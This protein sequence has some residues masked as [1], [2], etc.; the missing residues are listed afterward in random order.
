MI[1]QICIG[2]HILLTWVVVGY[3]VNICG[4]NSAFLWE[5]LYYSLQEWVWIFGDLCNFCWR[6]LWFYLLLFSWSRVKLV[7]HY[8]IKYSVY[9]VFN[10]VL[11]LFHK[12]WRMIPRLVQKDMIQ[13]MLSFFYLESKLWWV[14][15]TTV[16]RVLRV[17]I[18]ERPP[19]WRVAVN[20]LNK[21]LR[22]AD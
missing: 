5:M 1:Y 6:L 18:E 21:Q 20:K 11:N 13:W 8:G 22:T 17:R 3:L 4:Y 14:P 12:L 19:I 7:R 15:V 9:V 10:L 2:N 16:W